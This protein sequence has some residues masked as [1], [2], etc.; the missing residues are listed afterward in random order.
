MSPNKTSKQHG[1]C[2]LTGKLG[3]YVK[4]HILPEALTRPSQKGNPFL[5]HLPGSRTTRRWTSWYDNTIVTADGES[6]LSDL[7]D[8]G[9]RE[10]RRQR[11]VWSAWGPIQSM[12]IPGA[13]HSIRTIQNV[14]ATTLRLFLLSILWR[15]AASKLF[16]LA[17]VKLPYDDLIFLRDMIR[18]RTITPLTFCPISLV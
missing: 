1:R 7:D 10:L 13:S 2:Q 9:I 12:A 4:A 11:L 18:S 5:Q 14:D 15:A 17:H 6:I 16:E 3:P 8:R